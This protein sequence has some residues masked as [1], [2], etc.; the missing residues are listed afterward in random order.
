[1]TESTS[2]PD[3][4]LQRLRRGD[5]DALAELFSRHRERL[6]H[7]VNLRLDPRLAG[8]ADADDVLQEAYLDAE[9]RLD[10]YLNRHS[11]SL[12]V[13]L[14]MVVMQ[15][16]VNVH[17]R[18]LGARMRDAS[19]DMSIHTGYHGFASS[20]SLAMQ[21]L[22]HLTSPSQ[23]VMREEMAN[24]L[25][26]AI[27]HMDSIDREVLLLRHFEQLNNGEVADVLGIQ[28]KAASIRYIRA[29]K[30]LRRIVSELPG[31]LDE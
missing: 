14:R 13:W 30:K 3:A 6:W 8:R 15:T 4:L 31:F 22:G 18:H 12:F 29:L 7:I 1:M 19:R 9:A 10:H 16:V 20:T 26:D 24:Q 5:R 25:E 23:A 28:K 11:G 2:G 21:L 27:D 17:R